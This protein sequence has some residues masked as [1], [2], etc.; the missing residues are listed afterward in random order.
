MELEYGVG[1]AENGACFTKKEHVGPTGLG[2]MTDKNDEFIIT[3][4]HDKWFFIQSGDFVG[5]IKAYAS[6]LPNSGLCVYIKK[7]KVVEQVKKRN[8]KILEKPI[9]FYG[10]MIVN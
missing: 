1:T 7:D 10:K 9:K 6:A 4:D 5:D 8:S 2:Y 3:Y